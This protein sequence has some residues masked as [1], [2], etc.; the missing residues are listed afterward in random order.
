MRLFISLL[1]L[2]TSLQLYAQGVQLLGIP[3]DTLLKT[4]APRVDPAYITTYYS[5]LHIF[6]VSDRRNFSIRLPGSVHS[7]QYKPNLAWTLGLGFNYKWLGTELTFNMPLPGSSPVQKG[8]TKPFGLNLNYNNRRFW[9]SAQYQF[10]RGFYIANPDVIATNWLAFQPTYPY[11]NDLISQTISTHAYYLFNPLRLSIP[12][13][14]LQREG[15]RKNAGSWVVG[16]F[17]TYQLI[18]ADSSLIPQLIESDFS[19]ELTARRFSSLAIGV[20]AGYLRTFILGKYYFINLGVRPGLSLLVNQSTFTDQPALNHIGLGWQGQGS[21]T[22]GYNSPRYYGG[23]YAS[24]VLTN[25]ALFSN[26]LRTDSEYIRFVA[27]KRFRYK[28][29]G[30]MKKVPGL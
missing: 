20:D 6:L 21:I 11:R 17:F 25:R 2:T 7:L 23:I 14:L 19:A 5:R 26:F 12:A 8:K 29:K 4:K 15:Q 13:S 10:Y 22:I 18:R 30:L 28:P 9:A 3:L 24:A 16:S 27:G 1:L